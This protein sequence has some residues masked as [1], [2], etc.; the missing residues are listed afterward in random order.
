[1]SRPVEQQAVRGAWRLQ[2]EGKTHEEIGDAIGRQPRQVGN[3]LSLQWL[4]DRN[5]EHLSYSR[6]A[7]FNMER[8]AKSRC[9]RQDHSFMEDNRFEWQAYTTRTDRTAIGTRRITLEVKVC[10]FCAHEKVGRRSF[11]SGS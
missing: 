4:K 8:E 7:I 6:P 5:L 10:L 11:A 3:Y 2:R 9:V 1:M